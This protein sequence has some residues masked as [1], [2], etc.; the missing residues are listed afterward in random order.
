MSA[1][2]RFVTV[3]D[4]PEAVAKAKLLEVDVYTDIR[5]TQTIEDADVLAHFF[6]TLR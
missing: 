1:Q 3:A 4:R 6:A 5:R 2:G